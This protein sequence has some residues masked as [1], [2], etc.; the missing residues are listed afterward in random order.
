[1]DQLVT[2]TL[3]STQTSTTLTT[4]SVVNQSELYSHVYNY[5]RASRITQHDETHF[6]RECVNNGTCDLTT[7]DS[8]STFLGMKM[9]VDPKPLVQIVATAA[10]AL[11][12]TTQ[13]TLHEIFTTPSIEFDL[14]YSGP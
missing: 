10:A 14:G 1:M 6:C 8:V 4:Q 12:M 2:L 13:I 5:A 11:P 9:K 7:R 3:V